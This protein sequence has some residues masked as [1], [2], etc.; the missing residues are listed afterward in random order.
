M[1]KL[2]RMRETKIV[3]ISL[4][5]IAS[6]SGMQCNYAGPFLFW[7]NDNLNELK[8]PALQSKHLRSLN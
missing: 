2:I 8:I 7:G 1:I 5:V 3:L 4:M 6:I